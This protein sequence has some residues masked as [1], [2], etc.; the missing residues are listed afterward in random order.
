LE[1]LKVLAILAIIIAVI[2][3]F[4]PTHSLLIQFYEG[5]IIVKTMVDII[6]SILQGLGNAFVE[7]FKN[8]F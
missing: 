2:W 6:G 5:N 8:T 1:L 4:P 7:F 3:F